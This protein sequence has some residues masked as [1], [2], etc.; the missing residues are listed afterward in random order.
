MQH[1]ADRLGAHGGALQVD[2]RGGG[3][4]PPAGHRTELLDAAVVEAADEA[5]DG[6]LEHPVD[7]QRKRHDDEHP[8]RGDQERVKVRGEE[9]ALGP[10][11]DLPADRAAGAV[12]GAARGGAG[13]VLGALVERQGFGL[14]LGQD[15]GGRCEEVHGRRL[16]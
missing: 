8:E 6:A 16:R 7:D 5:L 11:V 15:G 13:K 12:L 1:P 14:D 10:P 2:R 4:R 9:A 3:Q